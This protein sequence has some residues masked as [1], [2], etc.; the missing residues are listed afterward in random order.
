MHAF[1]NSAFKIGTV[2][3]NH[4]LIQ[5]PLAGYSCAPFRRSFNKYYAPAYCV[6][7]MI[8]AQDVL[9]KHAPTS[10][11]LYRDP[12]EKILAYQISGN[13]ASLLAA[14]AL[15]LEN[16]GADIIDINC[17]CPKNKI[18]K[19]GAGSALLED[20]FK[21]EKIIAEVKAKIQIPLTVKIRLQKND[22]DFLIAEKVQNAGADALIVHG[23]T[24]EEDY[25][26]KAQ[27]T[28]LKEIKKIIKIPL[29]AN[30]DIVCNKSLADAL[31][32]SR[33][34]GFMISRAG[35]GKPWLYQELLTEQFIKPELEQRVEWFFEH[36]KGLSELENEFKAVLQ[37]RSL[38]R[39]YFREYRTVSSQFNILQSLA[40]IRE[41]CRQVFNSRNIGK[42]MKPLS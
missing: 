33:C 18:R 6:T 5:G 41:F 13:D 26:T 38:F 16:L 34:D 8:S 31:E 39:Y 19:K 12:Q 21:L 28:Q 20:P 2:N 15:K 11:Y 3:L 36:L 7:E 25:Q 22:N 32:S 35:T 29:I 24:W 30:G 23:R 1:L 27:W 4:R 14:A 17:G 40:E 42:P 10:R 37:S 9:Q